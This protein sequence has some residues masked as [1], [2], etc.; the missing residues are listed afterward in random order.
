MFM[1]DKKLVWYQLGRKGSEGFSG[2]QP[3][4]KSTLLLQKSQIPYCDIQTGLLLIRHV[5]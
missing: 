5:K 1:G 4:H 3:D 2:S